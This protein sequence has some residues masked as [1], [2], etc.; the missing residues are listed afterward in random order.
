MSINVRKG[1]HYTDLS[2]D[3][4]MKGMDVSAMSFHR[5]MQT[6]LKLDAMNDWG[7]ILGLSYI[8]AQRTFLII[9]IWLIIKRI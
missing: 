2:H 8:A 7:S 4:T 9:M 1:K 6:A 3:F 5:V